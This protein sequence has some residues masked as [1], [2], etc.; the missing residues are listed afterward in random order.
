MDQTNLVF[1]TAVTGKAEL[2]ITM[3]MIPFILGALLL[4]KVDI[5]PASPEY[6][7]QIPENDQC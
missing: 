4:L 1:A 7:P 2:G 5:P 3:L 6:K